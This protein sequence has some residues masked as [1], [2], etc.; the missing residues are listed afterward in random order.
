M[1]LEQLIEQSREIVTAIIN[2]IKE[3]GQV[4]EDEVAKLVEHEQWASDQISDLLASFGVE[5]GDERID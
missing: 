4:T 3:D 5:I 1:S 2:K